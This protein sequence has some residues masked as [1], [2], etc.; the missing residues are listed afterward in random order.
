MTEID[1]LRLKLTYP[2]INVDELE[3]AMLV[4]TGNMPADEL[5]QNFKSVAALM[6]SDTVSYQS[7]QMVALNQIVKGGRVNEMG[8]EDKYYPY[9]EMDD[10]EAKTIIAVDDDFIIGVPSYFLMGLIR[11]KRHEQG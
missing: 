9:I 11:D 7:K 10:P 1:T 2:D 8:Y 6:H 4:M 3:D 5:A